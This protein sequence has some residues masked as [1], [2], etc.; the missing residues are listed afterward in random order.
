MS[1]SATVRQL[2]PYM[3]SIFV[4]VLMVCPAVE[5]ATKA[6]VD[7]VRSSSTLTDTALKT[8]DDF[9]NQRFNALML[10][11]D[12]PEAS[13]VAKDLV[14]CVQS[15]SNV[16]ATKKSY[17]DRYSRAVKGVCTQALQQSRQKQQ[18]Q[19]PLQQK[20]GRHTTLS[21]VIIMAR[22]DNLIL[23]D[24]LIRL[25]DDPSDEIR[26]WAAKGLAG[27]NLNSALTTGRDNSKFIKPILQGL[28]SC[29]GKT[30]SEGVISQIALAADLL[31]RRASVTILEQC[32]TKRIDH[33][34][35]WQV[36]NE[37][38]DIIIISQILIVVGNDNIY[39]DEA[40]RKKLLQSAANL[41]TLAYQ[42]YI[43][44][45]RYLDGKTPLN[46]LRMQNQQALETLLIECE[47]KIQNLAVKRGAIPIIGSRFAAA[48][49]SGNPSTL[50]MA[51]RM[52][53]GKDGVTDKA[54]KITSTLKL[55]N[56][57]KEV[58]DRARTLRDIKKNLI[59]G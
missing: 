1:K 8:L 5:A 30:N 39:A 19:D 18:S 54:W 38:A 31:D 26:Y 36:I 11:K 40:T 25:L 14:D 22:C 32:V 6:D 37:S 27:R 16:T 43:K 42:R 46:L 29:L 21:T 35:R 51:Y 49:K 52:L 57:P 17:S 13:K 20:I 2:G 50:D 59:G 34:Q 58:V 55:A 7:K 41:Y 24:D 3:G 53:L 23:A 33:Y 9:V 28:N 15:M 47:K 56:P 44:G 45:T 10:V 48:I 12:L 4:F